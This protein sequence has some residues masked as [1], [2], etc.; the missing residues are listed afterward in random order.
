MSCEDPG[1]E[2]CD[3]E[4]NDCDT[5]TADGAGEDDFGA[6]CDGDDADLCADGV[7]VCRGGPGLVCDDD[8]DSAAELCDGEDNDCDPTTADGADEDTLGD[9]CDGPD[10][11]FCATGV[12][13]CSGGGMMCSDD[14]TPDGVEILGN[15]ED[16]DC[17]GYAQ[18]G[19][20]SLYSR[21]PHVGGAAAAGDVEFVF[22]DLVIV[23]GAV[24]VEGAECRTG[25]PARVAQLP[26]AACALFDDSGVRMRVRPW[27]LEASMDPGN[28]GRRETQIRFVLSDGN[29]SAVYSGGYYVHSSLAGAT[30]CTLNLGLPGQFGKFFDAARSY[31][32]RNDTPAFGASDLQAANPFIQIRFT[33]DVDQVFE[34]GEMDGRAEL[35]SLRRAFILEPVDG[36]LLLMVRTY[37][38]KRA[39]GSCRTASVRKH[40]WGS[41][42]YG[43]YPMENNN[44]SCDAIVFN[45]DGAG[46]C[47]QDDSLAAASPVYVGRG[48]ALWYAQTATFS[49]YYCEGD[50]LFDECADNFM[51]RKLSHRRPDGSFR[52]FSPKCINRDAC[53][54]GEVFLPGRSDFP[55]IFP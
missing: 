33:P 14:M 26:W 30:R 11:D 25:E 24:A 48:R 6:A 55:D 52:W 53:A 23:A 34:V 9:A 3:G 40:H 27:T 38:S 15:E 18:K 20:P 21:F 39:P 4:D 37:E 36:K 5:S 46:M 47:L 42:L 19:T 43:S 29:R 51:W 41:D 8:S 50:N 7:L 22:N 32:I 13:E 45:R 16:E 44:N 10:E 31:L 12:W 28:D 54:N 49:S 35:L 2:L 1:E 17:D